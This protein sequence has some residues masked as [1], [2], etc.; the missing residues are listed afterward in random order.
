MGAMV[1]GPGEWDDY[2]DQC[3]DYVHNEVATDYNAGLTSAL[4]ALK[5]LSVT[6]QLKSV[7]VGDDGKKSANI[8]K[9][10]N[11]RGANIHAEAKA[12]EERKA[13]VPKDSKV[14]KNVKAKGEN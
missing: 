10:S 13:E 3:S 4:A 14:V 12:K 9:V 8:I 11:L 1:G 6:K 7:E 5:H 2:S